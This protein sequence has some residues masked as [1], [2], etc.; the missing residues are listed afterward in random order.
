MQGKVEEEEQ[1]IPPEGY[2]ENVF[3]SQQM[4]MR[5]TLGEKT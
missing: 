5:S 1:V 2:R 4:I 3:P